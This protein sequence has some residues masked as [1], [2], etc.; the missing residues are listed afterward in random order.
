MTQDQKWISKNLGKLTKKYAGKYVAVVGEKVVASGRS[1]KK[2]ED[3]VRRR[4]KVAV[5]SIVLVPHNK[6]LLHVLLC[7]I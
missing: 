3:F 6:D 7:R 1:S 2:I 5:P 4:Y